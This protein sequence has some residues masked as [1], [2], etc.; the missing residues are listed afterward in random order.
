MRKCVLLSM[1]LLFVSLLSME[2][3]VQ[4]HGDHSAPGALP[5]PFFGGR[6]AEAKGP[7]DTASGELFFEAVY[8]DKKISVYPLLIEPKNLKVFKPLSA[9]DFLPTEISLTNP[10]TKKVEKFTPIAND[11]ALEVNFDMKDAKRVV[12]QMAVNHDG[13]KKV[14]EMQIEKK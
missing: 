9:K 13:M 11:K 12:L 14:L 7:T 2:T 10:R 5:P 8:K 6:L 4:A 1:G 3:L